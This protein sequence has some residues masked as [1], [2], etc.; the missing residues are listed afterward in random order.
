MFLLTVRVCVSSK[1]RLR[2]QRGREEEW[3][4]K[5]DRAIRI[6]SLIDSWFSYDTI[7]RQNSIKIIDGQKCEIKTMKMCMFS[8]V[9]SCFLFCG[10]IDLSH[11]VQSRILS[12]SQTFN[13]MIIVG[14]NWYWRTRM[15]VRTHSHKFER[16][17]DLAN[18]LPP[19]IKYNISSSFN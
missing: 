7:D 19:T 12:N 15:H 5:K 2:Y 6:S 9:R 4:Q 10:S 16:Q 1:M 18:A 13:I 17:I 11:V 3:K 14:N 8:F